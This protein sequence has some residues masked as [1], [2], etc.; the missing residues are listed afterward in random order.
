MAI[1]ISAVELRDK[2]FVPGVRA[3]LTETGLAPHCLELELTETFLMQD[4]QSTAT[5]LGA[6]KEMGVQLALDD[7]GTGFSSLSHLKRFQMDTLKIDQ[8]FVRNLTTDAGDAGIVSA[9]I[10]MGKSLHMRVVAEGIETPEQLAFLQEQS[11]LEGQ[12][13]YLSQ[14]LTVEKFTELLGRSVVE[15]RSPDGRMTRKPALKHVAVNTLNTS[16]KPSARLTS[17]D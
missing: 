14:P 17:G 11:C 9:V 1:N 3:I 4:S 12:G 15:P 13:Y 7:F 10:S 2:D 16:P 6:L 5:V 8:S